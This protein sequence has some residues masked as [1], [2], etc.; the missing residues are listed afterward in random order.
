MAA[1]FPK[2]SE[3]KPGDKLVADGGFTCLKDGQ[4]VTIED[5]GDFADGRF[6]WELG[7]IASLSPPVAA[8]GRQGLFDLPQGWLC[9]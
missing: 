8:R 2:L 6:A 9:P 7:E 4:I 3:L 1:P 5:L